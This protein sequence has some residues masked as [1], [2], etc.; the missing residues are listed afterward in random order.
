MKK[1]NQ[2]SDNRIGDPLYRA[3]KDK[4][5]EPRE[6][7]PKSTDQNGYHR[8]GDFGVGFPHFEPVKA[9]VLTP[10][11]QK[12][13][14]DQEQEQLRKEFTE[15][16]RAL[17]SSDN[18][19]SLPAG[20]QK[21]LFWFLLTTAAVLG[22]LLTS[23]TAV[24]INNIKEL[25][26]PFNWIA[27]VAGGVFASLLLL[28]IL[29]LSWQAMRLRRNPRISIK[30]LSVLEQ[31]QQFRKLVNVQA[32]QVKSKMQDYIRDYPITGSGMKKL[33]ALG[34]NQ[35]EIGSLSEARAFLLDEKNPLEF[36]H[37]LAEYSCRFQSTLDKQAKRIVK[38]YALK[39][40]TGTGISPVSFIDQMIVLYSS[41]AMIRDLM[42]IYQLRP[43]CGQTAIIL[44]RAILNT[45]LSGLLEDA[46]SKAAESISDSIGHWSTR[47]SGILSSSLGQ[48]ISSRITEATLNAVLISRLGKKTI[49]QLSIMSDR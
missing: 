7:E 14:Q 35:E 29:K 34:F 9:R 13:L 23:Q 43:A 18:T 2:Q 10:Q 39:V 41:T 4:K 30:A 17:E 1:D 6:T 42:Y 31:R 38:E 11:E 24:F 33:I 28:I 25:P 12:Q 49:K 44:S 26:T 8:E 15:K 22:L 36:S 46:S 32:E 40:G 45:Y 19:W 16:L 21:P 27:M 48:T 3:V 5:P 37:W 47:I 20:I